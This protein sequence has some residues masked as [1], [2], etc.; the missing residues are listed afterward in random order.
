MQ[1]PETKRCARCLLHCSSATNTHCSS[2]IA[3]PQSKP[4]LELARSGYGTIDWIAVSD[5]IVPPRTMNAAKSSSRPITQLA[6]ELLRQIAQHRPMLLP[7]PSWALH[8]PMFEALGLPVTRYRYYHHATRAL[9]LHGMLADLQA[10]PHGAVV[11][12]HACA[13]NPT[14]VDPSQEEWAAVLGVVQQRRLLPLFDV[15]YQVGAT[16]F[17]LLLLLL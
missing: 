10:A 17:M 6:G 1:R 13:H 7:D 11:L 14:G 5:L 15:A 3:S 2:A 4:F 8:R 9:D 16:V 12:L